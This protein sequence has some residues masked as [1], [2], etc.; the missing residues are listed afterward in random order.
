MALTR[1]EI[2]NERAW[3]VVIARLAR[4]DSVTAHVNKPVAVASDLV[5]DLM[6][7]SERSD[8]SVIGQV[9]HNL[10]CTAS[11]QHMLDRIRSLAH[12][13]EAGGRVDERNHPPRGMVV[14]ELVAKRRQH[15]RLEGVAP[16]IANETAVTGR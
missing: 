6:I 13:S 7:S 10:P 9:Q 4:H 8:T 11:R 1:I 5:G 14:I 12:P 16:H 3:R 15:T 2:R